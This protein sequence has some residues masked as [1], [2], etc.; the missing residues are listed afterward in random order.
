MNK[1]VALVTGAA[2]GIGRA[3]THKLI[4]NG[5]T[6][7]VSDIQVEAGQQLVEEIIKKRGEALFVKANVGSSEEVRSLI[8]QTID[9]YGRLDY[10][11]NNAGIGGEMTLLHEIDDASWDQMMRVNLSSVFYCM[12][13][14]LKVMTQ[15][16]SG[17]I[18]NVSSLAG[19]GGMIKGSSYSAAKHGVLGLTRTA[20]I[21]YG[22]MNIRV[23]A[24]CPGYTKTAILDQIDESFLDKSVRVFVPMRRL[25]QPEEIADAVYWLLSDQSSFVNGHSL[26]IDG[27]FKAS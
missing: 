27:G 16:G 7:V 8:K 17:G 6:V 3:V 24:V 9:A 18:V 4:D 15:Q 21:E 1:K 11:V 25:G 20:A 12:R 23:N 5:A 2:S 13:E 14:E 10:A 26:A 22:R 19:L